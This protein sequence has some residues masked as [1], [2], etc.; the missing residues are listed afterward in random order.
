MKSIY[1]NF[2]A[3]KTRW[4]SWEDC[5]GTFHYNAW[6]P[7]R[8]GVDDETHIR[9]TP[10]QGKTFII[11]IETCYLHNVA[12]SQFLYEYNIQQCCYCACVV[13]ENSGW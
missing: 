12:Y 8:N 2:R 9:L 10:L 11:F 3:G 7:D 6:W 5:R 1:F 4:N 13:L